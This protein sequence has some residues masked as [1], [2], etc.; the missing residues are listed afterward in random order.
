M[1]ITLTEVAK[2]H[3]SVDV[4]PTREEEAGTTPTA[5]EIVLAL[6]SVAGDLIKQLIVGPQ[7]EKARAGKIV[8]PEFGPPKG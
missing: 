4:E 6:N 1:K 5:G 7:A 3:W 2:G 8:I